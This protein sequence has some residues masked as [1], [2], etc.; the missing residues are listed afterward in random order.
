MK[1]Y[2]A[3]LLSVVA[4]PGIATP[5]DRA[6]VFEGSVL[7]AHGQT[8]LDLTDELEQI[9]VPGVFMGW[10]CYVGDTQR[11]GA[12]YVKQITC[13]GKW[14][15]VDTFVSCDPSHRTNVATLRLRQPINGTLKEIDAAEKLSV[16]VS[17][18]YLRR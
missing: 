4:T 15:F 17:C 5:A 18:G 3:A 13:G 16:S 8:R 2:V 10:I 9:S 7:F 12:A 14:G 11:N 6:P 1:P